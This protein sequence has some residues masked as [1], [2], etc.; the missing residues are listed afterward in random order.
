VQ[1][2][3]TF[4]QEFVD[5]KVSGLPQFT[6]N[7]SS[8]F[9]N[10]P[11]VPLPVWNATS[12]YLDTSDDTDNYRQLGTE[13]PLPGLEGAAS[14]FLGQD[15]IKD[16]QLFD[17]GDTF[18]FSLPDLDT[19]SIDSSKTYTPLDGIFDLL[20]EDQAL[21]PFMQ[22]FDDH[23]IDEEAPAPIPAAAPASR[24]KVRT[25]PHLCPEPGCEKSF[26]YP[27]DVRRH[28]KAVHGKIR[29]FRCE[30]PACKYADRGFP[31]RDQLRRHQKTAHITNGPASGD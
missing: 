2:N 4:D 29:D 18:S 26:Q 16:L 12:N 13:T 23:I 6:H 27:K 14:D 11:K 3:L 7:A 8:G 10:E 15:C 20:S 17:F 25:R 31:R 28:D 19:P 5:T 9:F 24:P 21:P 30:E 1:N 22:V